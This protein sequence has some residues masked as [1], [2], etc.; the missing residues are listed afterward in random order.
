MKSY[1]ILIISLIFTTKV[2]SQTPEGIGIRAGLNYAE[3]GITDANK[4]IHFGAYGYVRLSEKIG[5]QPEILY[6]KEGS[7]GINLNYLDI[8][9][10]LKLN[11][12]SGFNIHLGPE[13]GYLLSANDEDG[14]DI[15]ASYEKLKLSSVLGVGWDTP[16]GFQFSTKY[17]FG[18]TRMPVDDGF[19]GW[20]YQFSIGY[21]L[22]RF[23]D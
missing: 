3:T 11:S 17:I 4:G 14:S 22:F 7:F 15:K 1:L 16:S 9:I 19:K 20:V 13:V 23:S 5:L 2:I 6:S 12:Q 8:P 10:L 18:L 21:T